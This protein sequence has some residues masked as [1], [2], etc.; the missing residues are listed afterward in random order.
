MRAVSPRPALLLALGL[1]LPFAPAAAECERG[2]ARSETIA[3]L[4]PR[5]EM[6]FASGG[7]AVLSSLRWPDGATEAGDGLRA[8]VG[9]RI[10]AI[11]R[12]PPD[13]WGRERIDASAEEDGADL[14]GTLIAGGL[15]YADAG[16]ADALCRPALR[17]V[18]GA[19]R[20]RRLGVWRE[21][22]P[23]AGD[24]PALR[25]LAGRFAVVEGRIRHVGER[26]ARTYLDFVP[27]G[28]DGLTVVV[29]KRHWRAMAGRGLTADGLRDRRVR[30]RGLI[31]VWRGPT[32][33]AATPDAI[34][35]LDDES[36][37]SHGGAGDEEGVRR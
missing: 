30:V 13:R 32:I 33:E 14:A 27:R 29:T 9:R 1:A 20:A 3:E 24:G 6:R 31:E 18:E 22:P 15:A 36:P 25:R 4:G 37:V 26:G 19:A 12:G 10:L 16:E 21:D 17:L 11:P 2:A 8:W 7:R 28:T 23:G 5:G 34:E 35:R